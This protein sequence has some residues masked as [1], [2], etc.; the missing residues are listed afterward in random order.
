MKTLLPMATVL[1]AS[2]VAV[3]PAVSA[4]FAQSIAPLAQA[5]H[6]AEVTSPASIVI[7]DR[8]V[9][10][11]VQAALAKDK[12]V[13]ALGLTVRATNGA[14]ELSGRAVSQSQA[15]RAVALARTVPG[16]K[17]VTNEIRLN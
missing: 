8:E 4:Q 2:T 17:S 12:N 7:D 3:V 13:G 10:L 9:T 11:R 1:V 16:V 14:V 6:P 5:G 15:D